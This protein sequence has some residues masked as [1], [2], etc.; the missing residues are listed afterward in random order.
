MVSLSSV[1]PRRLPKQKRSRH[2]VQRI[3]DAARVIIESEGLD[4]LTTNRIAAQT[5]LSPGS[6]YQYFPNKKAISVAVLE[7]EIGELRNSLQKPEAILH[8]TANAIRQTMTQAS[9]SAGIFRQL[10]PILDEGKQQG[11]VDTLEK[12]VQ[13]DLRIQIAASGVRI[14][15]GN[16]DAA[17]FVAIE[18]HL[19]LMRLFLLGE[20]PFRNLEEFIAMTT[21][22]FRRFLFDDDGPLGDP[23]RGGERQCSGCEPALKHNLTGWNR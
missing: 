19:R 8:E 21:D 11:F 1:T 9:R 18:S 15:H 2:L 5:N 3:I 17:I 12:R 20:S 16:T 7:Q 22:L 13:Q 10:M 14:R 23:A 6:I 4:A